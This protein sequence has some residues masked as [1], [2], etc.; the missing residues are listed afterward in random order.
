MTLN[1]YTSLAVQLKTVSNESRDS[2]YRIIPL[3][4]GQSFRTAGAA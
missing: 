3:V 1:Q 4:G 2:N